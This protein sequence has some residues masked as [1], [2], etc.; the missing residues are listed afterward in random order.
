MISYAC[1][2]SLEFYFDFISPYAYLGWRRIHDVAAR[3]GRA[4]VARPVLFAAL[5]D[6]H[7]QRGPAEIP[8][9]RIYTWKH[10][11]RLAH[12]QGVTLE[13]PPAHPFNP[14]AALRT[15]S[16]I[17]DPGRQRRAIDAL[18]DATW[19]GGGGVADAA[20]VA[21]ALDAAGL[22]GA[23]LVEAAGRP[24]A[25]VRLRA[26]TDTA[27]ARGVFGVPTVVVDDEVFWG[28]DSFGHVEA[29]LRGEDPASE[30]AIARWRGL[31]AG[32]VRPGSRR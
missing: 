26:E 19:G 3:H 21:R 23:R 4:V 24:D 18:Y 10:V 14:L 9:K 6:A 29:F 16:M 2:V 27:I 22:P 17:E 5:L 32:A 25:K 1:G 11:V 31:P 12:E 15:V 28:Q 7:G 30:A 8:S 20:D 13:P